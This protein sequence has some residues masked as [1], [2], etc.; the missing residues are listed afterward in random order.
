[1]ALTKKSIFYPTIIGNVPPY[2]QNVLDKLSGGL[3]LKYGV[4]PARLAALTARK[5][6]VVAAIDKKVAD[7]QTA[8]ASTESRDAVLVLAKREFKKVLTDIQDH[9]AFEEADME[10][11]GGRVISETPDLDT[12]KPVIPS[13]TSLPDKIVFDWVKSFLDG[14]FAESSYD[15]VNWNFKDKDLRSPWED[16]RKNQTLNV[17]EARYYRFRYMKGDTAVG[18]YT[19]VIKVVCEIY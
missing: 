3:D 5:V 7:D 4:T 19:D 10:A 18:L 16:T 8:Q 12:V 13:I 14:L 11:L 15:G 6:S 2:Q 17:P 9:L 1:M